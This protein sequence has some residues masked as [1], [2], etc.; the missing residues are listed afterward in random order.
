MW[1]VCVSPKTHFLFLDSWKLCLHISLKK[2]I[3]SDEGQNTLP[4]ATPPH[5]LDSRTEF[6]LK[7]TRG[8]FLGG[9][10]PGVASKAFAEA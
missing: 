10:P 6:F 5:R 8:P 4:G 9:E 7:T 2:M 1:G 3:T